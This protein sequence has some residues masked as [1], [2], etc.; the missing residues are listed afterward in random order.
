MT[1]VQ[2]VMKMEQQLQGTQQ[3][4]QCN[5]FLL[6]RILNYIMEVKHL[7]QTSHSLLLAL[8]VVKWVLQSLPYRNT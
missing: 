5:V 3:I 8:I 7:L 6:E 2:H 4:I 1:F